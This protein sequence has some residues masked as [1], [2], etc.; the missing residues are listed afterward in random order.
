MSRTYKDRNYKQLEREAL[1]FGFTYINHHYGLRPPELVGDV[2][3]YVA[4][5]GRKAHLRTYNRWHDWR[6]YESDWAPD[7]GIPSAIR[8]HLTV[9]RHAANSGLLDED[10]DDPIVYQRHIRW[11]CGR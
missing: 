2:D 11:T 7:Y 3:A 10:W 6:D 4:H 8:D 9:A 5:R 1:R